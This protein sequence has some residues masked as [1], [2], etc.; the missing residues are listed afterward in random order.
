MLFLFRIVSAPNSTAIQVTSRKRSEH[1]SKASY[2][3]L[4]KLC[5]FE[6]YPV[7]WMH[8]SGQSTGLTFNLTIGKMNAQCCYK[9]FYRGMSVEITL[10]TKLNGLYGEIKPHNS[11]KLVVR[12][13]MVHPIFVDLTVMNVT[14]TAQSRIFQSLPRHHVKDR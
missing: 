6:F 4:P 2:A 10:V 11:R 3:C 12:L 14:Q 1:R 7:A 9:F 13:V 5:G 8:S